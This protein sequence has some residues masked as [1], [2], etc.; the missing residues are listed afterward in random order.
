MT[1][2]P[3]PQEESC[4]SWKISILQI[5][6]CYIQII[7][8]KKIIRQKVDWQP[9]SPEK[10]VGVWARSSHLLDSVNMNLFP[11]SYDIYIYIYLVGGIPT[12]LKNMTVNWDHYSQYME[13]KDVPNHQ[14]DI[15]WWLKSLHDCD[16]V[17][18]INRQGVSCSHCSYRM[19]PS[20]YKLG[21]DP[22]YSRTKTQTLSKLVRPT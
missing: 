11:H 2:S 17:F 15:V 9:Q 14:P 5:R 18:C 10:H 13:I 22:I 12:P 4:I 7:K 21:Y 1:F 8:W 20:H 3:Q 16:D 19:W 6:S